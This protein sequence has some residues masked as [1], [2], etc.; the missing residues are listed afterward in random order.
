MKEKYSKVFT[1]KGSLLLQKNAGGDTAIGRV[2]EVKQLDKGFR[3][4]IK[5]KDTYFYID[6]DPDDIVVWEKDEVQE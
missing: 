6:I 5:K 3:Y 1:V 2:T 4:F